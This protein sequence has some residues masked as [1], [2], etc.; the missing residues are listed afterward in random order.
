M[1]TAGQE[2]DWNRVEAS[3]RYRAI[4][5]VSAEFVKQFPMFSQLLQQFGVSLDSSVDAQG[6]WLVDLAEKSH[7]VFYV[8]DAVGSPYVP[9]QEGFVHK[10]GVVSPML[11]G[12]LPSRDLFAVILFS[13]IPIPRE[14]AKLFRSL[15]LSAKSSFLAFDETGPPDSELARGVGE[16][17][18][19]LPATASVANVRRSNC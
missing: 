9:V 3:S 19:G 7:N 6:G 1:A 5:M 8:P 11:R 13:R 17:A 12:L 16:G 4:P 10:Y 2:P 14:T 15:A 18:T